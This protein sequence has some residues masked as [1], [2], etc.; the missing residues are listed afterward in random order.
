M[1]KRWLLPIVVGACVGPPPREPYVVAPDTSVVERVVVG[2]S[3]EMATTAY[4]G[5]RVTT[6]V[7]GVDLGTSH[8]S[9]DW[10]G[11]GLKRESE[12][13][14]CHDQGVE[15]KVFCSPRDMCEMATDEDQGTGAAS[16]PVRLAKLGSVKATLEVNN[17]ETGNHTTT[18]RRF[19]VIPPTQIR[20]QCMTPALAW[21]SCDAGMSAAK[22]LLRVMLLLDGKPVRSSL[23]RVN[24]HAATSS[25]SFT[26]GQSLEPILG[27]SPIAPGTYELDVAVGDLHEHV[28]VA[29]Q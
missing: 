15:A 19:E 7:V 12:V 10:T 14:G 25:S 16:I 11:L 4:G 22:P 18:V 2:A 1:P 27:S 3:V 9:K 17:L 20:V 23:L 21:G 24:G 8:S 5:C 6:H 28:S 29:I 13:V 26:I